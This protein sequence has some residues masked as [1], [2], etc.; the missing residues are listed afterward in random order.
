M[1]PTKA[2]PG[3]GPPPAARAVLLSGEH[4]TLPLAELRALLAVHDPHASVLA[5]G[6]VAVVQPGRP[7]ATDAALARM[8][9]AHEWGLLWGQAPETPAGLETLSVVARRLAD[10]QG[11][12]AVATTRTGTGKA[13]G[14]V[15][16]ERALGA[17]LKAAGHAIDLKSP[18][19]TAFGWLADGRIVCGERL[20]L[21]DRG[22]FESRASDER[23]HFSPVSLHPRRAASLLHLARVP[24]GGRV[25]DPFCGTGAFVLEAA[26]EGYETWGSDLDAFMVQ[27]TLQTLADAGP[28]PLAGQ[29]FVADVGLTPSL[30][31]PVDGIV[32]DLPYGRASGTEGEELRPLYQRAFAAFAAL[33]QAGGRA[34]IG[35]P[36]PTLLDGLEAHGLRV[37]ERYAEAVHRSLTRHYAVV[38]KV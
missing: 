7:E 24:P 4:D 5:D 10:G 27:G 20:G 12:V 15:A 16:V 28:E 32:T 6:R 17:A 26:L 30:M 18:S 21:N 33:L 2:L 22:R 19:R 31:A 29:A 35:H 1:P 11:S 23:A 34:V 25:Y 38:I 37:E 3:T 36:D 8:A 14:R 9:L 13:V